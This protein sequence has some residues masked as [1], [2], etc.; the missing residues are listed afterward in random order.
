MTHQARTSYG[1]IVNRC[2]PCH[3]KEA[4]ALWEQSQR[5]GSPYV[6][7]KASQELRTAGAPTVQIFSVRFESVRKFLGR[8]DTKEI[9]EPWALGWILGEFDWDFPGDDKRSGRREKKSL[10]L[11]DSFPKLVPC[12]RSEDQNIYIAHSSAS[13]NPASYDEVAAAIHRL[14][15]TLSR[16][17]SRHRGLSI[18]DIDAAGRM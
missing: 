3:E 18:C 12:F 17:R 6:H 10:A 4:A 1:G 11:I 13:G 15:G 2:Q 9:Y 7:G 14:A 5:S 8:W 16:G